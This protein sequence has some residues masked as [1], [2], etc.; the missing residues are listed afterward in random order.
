MLNKTLCVCRYCGK[1][2]YVVLY[3]Y[4]NELKC[5]KCGS[6]GEYYIWVQKQKEKVDYYK[7]EQKEPLIKDIFSEYTD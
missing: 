5:E 4:R 2:W 6:R 1:D 7:G 3:G